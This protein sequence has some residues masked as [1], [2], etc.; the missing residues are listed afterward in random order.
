MCG[1]KRSAG[2]RFTRYFT[3]RF[4]CANVSTSDRPAVSQLLQFT[5]SRMADF[6]RVY[7]R[8]YHSNV[9]RDA[10]YNAMT[11]PDGIAHGA[12]ADA[13]ELKYAIHCNVCA[14]LHAASF[15]A[16][17]VTFLKGYVSWWM[18]ALDNGPLRRGKKGACRD[19]FIAR[20][21]GRDSG[22]SF[23]GAWKLCSTIETASER[24]DNVHP[25]S[26][27]IKN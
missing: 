8:A 23:L 13:P 4:R 12:F 24:P 16:R 14:N 20:D 7:R 10:C 19:M 11:L 9:A 1:T 22:N 2:S 25:E 15:C 5:F 26:I 21:F 17:K 18:V 6:L 3:C 27:T